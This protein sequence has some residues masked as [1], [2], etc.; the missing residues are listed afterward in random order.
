MLPKGKQRSESGQPGG[1]KG[2]VDVV[3]T[4]PKYIH[5]DP[6]PTEGY[7]GYEESGESE[8]IP[9]ERLAGGN[10]HKNDNR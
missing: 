4:V 8:I 2:R 9:P 1:G 3:G 6:N 7:P 10:P 5:V